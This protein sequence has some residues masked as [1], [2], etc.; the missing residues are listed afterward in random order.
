MN[1]NEFQRTE[2][3]PFEVDETKLRRK[4]KTGAKGSSKKEIVVRTLVSLLLTAL[5]CF[6]LVWTY[7][8]TIVHGPSEA[9]KE[10]FVLEAS[11]NEA[12]SWLPYTLLPADEIE[13]ILEKA[14]GLNG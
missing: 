12:I 1:N 7:S 10:R 14:G 6:T 9:M 11:E 5:L 2:N 8:Y 3:L 4:P 13:A